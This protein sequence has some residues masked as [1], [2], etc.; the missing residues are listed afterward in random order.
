MQKC[1][2]FVYA[3]VFVIQQS[4]ATVTSENCVMVVTSGGGDKVEVPHYKIQVGI[5]CLDH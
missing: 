2:F 4:V 3:F 5:I 1:C